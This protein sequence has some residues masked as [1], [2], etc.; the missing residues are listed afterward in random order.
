MDDVP[1]DVD[2]KVTTDGA[3]LRGQG[4]GGANDLASSGDDALALPDHSDDRAGDDVLHEPSEEGLGGQ[5]GVVLLGERLLHVLELQTFEVEA[6]LLEAADDLADEAPLDAV[7]LDH[8]EG[9]L[10]HC[11]CAELEISDSV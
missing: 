10:G 5:I 3:G 9:L 2:G 4:V 6:L 7:R 11:C 8:D 1:A